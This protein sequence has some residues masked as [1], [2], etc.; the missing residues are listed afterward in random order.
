M[1]DNHQPVPLA[2][3]APDGRGFWSLMLTQLQGVFSDNVLKNLVTFL[4]LGM[5]LSLQTRDRLVLVVGALFSLPFIFFSMTGG[6]LADRFSKRAVTVAI[7]VME[8][9]TMLLALAGLAM[10]SL[11]LQLAAI[12]LL[13]TQ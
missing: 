6:F 4:V 7:K 12:F 2:T 13:S 11:P 3:R 9:C 10:G 5:G 8:L 1:D